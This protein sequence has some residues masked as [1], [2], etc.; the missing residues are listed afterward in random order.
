MDRDFNLRLNERYQQRR[1]IKLEKNK[2]GEDEGEDLT[3]R[4]TENEKML[5]IL[6]TYQV[7]TNIN[8]E[9]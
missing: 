6:K 1:V 9:N 3:D 2:S 5:R 7:K 4:E 8:Q